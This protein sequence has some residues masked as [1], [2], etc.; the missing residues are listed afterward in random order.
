M[1]MTRKFAIGTDIGGSH[2]SCALIDL[3]QMVI[4]KESHTTRKV[5]NTASADEILTAWAYTLDSCIR[6]IDKNQ[7]SGIG[8]AM[9]GPFDYEKGI[10]MFTPEV[11]K[12]QNL[13]KTDVR[14]NLKLKLGLADDCDLRF[15]NDAT[16]FAIGEA[17]LGKAKG[18]D[19][20]VAI[21]L[22]TGFGS[23]FIDEGVP[24]VERPD[25]PAQGCVW[26]LPFRNGIADDYFSTRWFTRRYAEKSGKNLTGAKE[27]AGQTD[28]DPLA[29]EVFQEFGRNLGDFLGPWLKSFNAGILVIGGNVSGAYPLF[30][31][32]LAKSFKIQNL[33]VQISISELKEDA[34][35]I[36]SARLLEDEF[37]EKIK[38]LLKQM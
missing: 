8:F 22:G 5:D 30:E 21:T 31:K 16:S 18:Y 7:L 17:W 27:I 10:A 12:Y 26:Y 36:G 35:I 13:F 33:Q 3:E 4:L 1:I 20:S 38:P 34:A 23:A 37:W 2:I 24:V 29:I 9:P 32:Y 28:Y 25:V 14:S 15:I 11:V 19:R 6:K